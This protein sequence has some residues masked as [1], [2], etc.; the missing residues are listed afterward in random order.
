VQT[1]KRVF[2]LS[3]NRCAFPRCQSRI[4]DDATGKPVGKIAHICAASPGGP[5]YDSS[6][7]DEQRRSYDNLLLLCGA[8]ADV[9]DADLTAYTVDRLREMK[10]THERSTVRA[11]DP[12]EQATTALIR[13][14]VAQ[15]GSPVGGSVITTINQVGGQVAHN[16]VN[17]GPQPRSLSSTQTAAISAGLREVP[18]EQVDVVAVLG[19][20]EAFSLASQIHGALAAGGWPVGEGIA[21]AV[22]A[23]PILGIVLKTPTLTPSLQRLGN[24]LL[25]TGLRVEAVRVLGDTSPPT[26]IVGANA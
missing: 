16:I 2:A 12:S 7:T 9:V 4:I 13:A 3:G 10:R 21:Q 17:V 23:G 8:H 22:F 11:P 1:V 18:H 19:D 24:L 26:I 15:S 6:M 20:G 5:R 14:S 25:Q